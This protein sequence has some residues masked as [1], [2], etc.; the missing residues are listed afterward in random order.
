MASNKVGPEDPTAALLGKENTD[1]A[2]TPTSIATY[3]TVAA[4]TD[5]DL[6]AKEQYDAIETE[7]KPPTDP[8]YEYEQL[9]FANI[10]FCCVLPDEEMDEEKA[11][12]VHGGHDGEIKHEYEPL[13][14]EQWVHLWMW[15]GSGLVFMVALI[16]GSQFFGYC[17]DFLFMKADE[18]ECGTNDDESDYDGATFLTIPAPF[19]YLQFGISVFGGFILRYVLG[20]FVIHCNL[21]VNYSR[22]I[23][24]FFETAISLL[25]NIFLAN[26]IDG[27]NASD[28]WIALWG[29]W[30]VVYLKYVVLSQPVRERI[31]FFM[32]QFK[33]LDRPE[34]RPYTI[35]W[36]TT[37]MVSLWVVILILGALSPTAMIIAV[38]IMNFGDGLAE[39]V[40]ITWGKHK[41]KVKA[42]MTRRWYWRSYEGSAT[43]FVVSI[44][45]VIAGYFIV[46]AWS[47]LQFFL[48]LIIVPPVAT[49]AEAVS[50]H[51]WDSA[52]VTGCSGLAI[53][54]IE[55]LP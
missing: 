8:E 3:G 33:A 23:N 14:A 9:P 6:A 38:F 27:F 10:F 40:G 29:V 24:L 26:K 4:Q 50:P 12:G 30:I 20:L 21:K 2:P 15:T 44:I 42:F 11:P 52:S 16:L 48:M 45:S 19:W 31:D 35:Y 17:E 54:L 41:Y 47:L 51:T 53:A 18:D 1:T 5:A 43:V 28:V 55:L 32:V 22:K 39:P 46:G 25:I 34:D 36:L 13:T 49:L 7:P 37:Q